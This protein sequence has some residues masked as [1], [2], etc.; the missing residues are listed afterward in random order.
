MEYSG[1]ADPGAKPLG[2]GGDRQHGLSRRRKQQAVNRGLVV[3]GDVGDG[4]GQSEHEVEVA[5][6]Q[7]FGLALGEPLLGGGCLTL[8]AV[9]IAA[10]VVGN[11]GIGAVL[12]TRDMTS[13]RHRTTALDG[14]H[15]L[16]LVEADVS[17]IGF[18]PRRPWS[19]KI[20]ATSNAGRDTAAGGYAGGGSFRLFLDFLRG[21]DSRSSGL[22]MPAIMPVA[23]R[24]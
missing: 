22:S 11:D 13:E 3:V 1:D 6:G 8:G 5:D 21:W 17:G 9:P 12:A 4:T 15:H 18:A 7:Q 23:T 14:R 2:I 16:D 19:R 20:S 10:A 24:V